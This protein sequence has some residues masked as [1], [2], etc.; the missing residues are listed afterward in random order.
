MG[1][2]IEEVE[3]FI[4][5]IHLRMGLNSRNFKIPNLKKL[6]YTWNVIMWLCHVS[7]RHH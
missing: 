2:I 5:S 3:L 4:K 1:I 7:S 6:N